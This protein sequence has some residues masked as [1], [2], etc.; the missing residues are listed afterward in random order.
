MGYTFQGSDIRTEQNDN[1]STTVQNPQCNVHVCDG[2][3][4]ANLILCPHCVKMRILR[5]L[6]VGGS[7]SANA[8]HMLMSA[9]VKQAIHTSTQKVWF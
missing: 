4:C 9:I 7:D 8:G 5:G 3:V 2:H 6:C 1:E